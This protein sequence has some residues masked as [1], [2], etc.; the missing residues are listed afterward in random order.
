M[1]PVN[2]PL[3]SDLFTH[4]TTPTRAVDTTYQNTTSSPILVVVG[5]SVASGGQ[6]NLTMDTTAA[7]VTNTYYS[8]AACSNSTAG[9]LNMGMSAIVPPG[10]YYRVIS[11]TKQ[12]WLEVA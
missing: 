10:Y 2:N 3:P 5:V 8:A 12:I 9:A 4:V 1:S 6:S 11:G 7:N